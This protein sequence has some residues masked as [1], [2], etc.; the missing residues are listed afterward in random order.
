M[1]RPSYEKAACECRRHR[2]DVEQDGSDRYAMGGMAV[3]QSMVASD[4][5]CKYRVTIS[6]AYACVFSPPGVKMMHRP[7]PLTDIEM[8]A[9]VQRRMQPTF[10]VADCRVD[11]GVGIGFAR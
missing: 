6:S 1:I 11:I 4:A 7:A 5:L 10:G 2:A 9:G 8:L 3:K